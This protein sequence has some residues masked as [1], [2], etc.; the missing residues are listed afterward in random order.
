MKLVVG[1]EL[2]SC[3]FDTNGVISLG[4]VTE[5]HSRMNEKMSYFFCCF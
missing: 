2:F 3:G 5:S 1:E 4:K